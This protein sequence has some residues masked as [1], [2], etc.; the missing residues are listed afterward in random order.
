[1]Y[2]FIHGTEGD[3]QKRKRQF[4]F[5]NKWF[6]IPLYRI[7]ILPLF[8]IGRIVVL[9]YHTGRKSGKQYRTPVEYRK[10]DGKILVFASRGDR[11]DWYRNIRANPEQFK[12]KVGFKSYHPTMT[13]PDFDERMEI[14]K[15]YVTEH[16]STAN[17]LFGWN[18]NIDEP[19]DETLSG[20][21]E[22]I[23]IIAF[24]K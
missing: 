6:V 8:G 1:M 2:D 23:K 13:F 9:L 11:T 18:K 10:K 3:Q 24:E 22:F 21:T 19:T 16:S 12:L 14:M 7:N 20:L 15:W 17:E 5:L 4:R